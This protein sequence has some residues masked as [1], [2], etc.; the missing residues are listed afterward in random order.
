MR[1][2]DYRFAA[3]AKVSLD[4]V[5]EEGAPNMCIDCRQGVVHDDDVSVEVERT[6]DVHALFLTATQVDALLAYLRLVTSG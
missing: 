1:N 2:E 5:L 3:S 4:G 6:G